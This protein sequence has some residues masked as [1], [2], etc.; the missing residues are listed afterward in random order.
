M[1]LVAGG[2]IGSGGCGR[3]YKEQGPYHHHYHPPH[4]L[5]HQHP[6]QHPLLYHHHQQ[7]QAQHISSTGQDVTG[8]YPGAQS[9]Y[10]DGYRQHPT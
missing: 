3:I 10:P 2:P 8:C 1:S 4:H 6:Q 7:Q 5:P 9:C